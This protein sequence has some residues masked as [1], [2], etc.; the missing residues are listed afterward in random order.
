MGSMHTLLLYRELTSRSGFNYKYHG[1]PENNAFW[2]GALMDKLRLWLPNETLADKPYSLYNIFQPVT[3]P[4][5][6]NPH[7]PNVEQRRAWPENAQGYVQFGGDSRKSFA[8]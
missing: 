8:L 5:I 7:I 1:L 6:C 4:H 3:H 2:P